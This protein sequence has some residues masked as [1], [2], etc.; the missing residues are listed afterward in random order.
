MSSADTLLACV[1]RPGFAIIGVVGGSRPL[2][3]KADRM[4][5]ADGRPTSEAASWTQACSRLKHYW[6]TTRRMPDPAAVNPCR[7]TLE[8]Q[9]LRRQLEADE[10]RRVSLVAQRRRARSEDPR[11]RARVS[12]WLRGQAE[13]SLQQQGPVEHCGSTG[14][15]DCRWC[16]GL[17]PFFVLFEPA[18]SLR[19]KRSNPAAPSGTMDCFVAAL[20]AMTMRPNRNSLSPE[21]IN[22]GRS[23]R[24]R[25]R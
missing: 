5:K 8:H 1:G 24:P 11:L 7:E 18:P 19:A 14:P 21:Q 13:R 15:F 12:F 25:A 9:W 20:L 6:M 22:R 17:T 23:R 4:V 16:G 10:P 3:A 2:R